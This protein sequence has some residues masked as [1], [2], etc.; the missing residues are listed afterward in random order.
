MAARCSQ[1]AQRARRGHASDE[2]ERAV[3]EL[4]RLAD[5]RVHRADLVV[6]VGAFFAGLLQEQ[7]SCCDRCRAQAVSWAAMIGADVDLDPAALR[8]E[9]EERE[10]RV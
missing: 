10:L 4:F 3:R 9:R 2:V 7:T 1:R 6:A 8:H 5:G